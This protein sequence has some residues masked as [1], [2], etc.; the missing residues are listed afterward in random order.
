MNLS[1]QELEENRRL[2]IWQRETAIATKKIAIDEMSHASRWIMASVL[3]INSGG[4][5]ATLGKVDSITSWASGAVISFYLGVWLALTMGWKSIKSNQ[6]MLNPH[7]KVIAFWEMAAVDGNMNEEE[8]KRIMTESLSQ[9][10][11]IKPHS[12]YGQWSFFLF[13][14]GVICLAFSLS[15]E[16]E[17]SYKSIS[18]SVNDAPHHDRR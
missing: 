18:P 8:H 3:A 10:V 11:N 1:S 9:I 14:I 2:A 12:H 16:K 4:L 13:S 7:S 17:N 5:I 15:I 6:K